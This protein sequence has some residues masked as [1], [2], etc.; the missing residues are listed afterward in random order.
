MKV[1]FWLT[2][3]I[4]LSFCKLIVSQDRITVEEYI[5]MYKDL[6]IEEMQKH[7]IPASIT[8]A[9]GLLESNTGNSPLAQQANNHF[10]IKC[11]KEWT[12]KTFYQD[13]DEK[14]ECFRKYAKAEDSYRDHSDYLRS[15]KRYA[16]LFELKVTDYKGWSRGLKKAGY[17]TSPTYAEKLID[18]IEDYNLQKYDDPSTRTN[19]SEK[20]VPQQSA[21]TGSRNIMENNRVKY[22]LAAEGD[23]YE[24]LTDEFGKLQWELP[25]YN[26]AETGY[27]VVP[28]QIVYIQPKRKKAESGKQIHVTRNGE[29][30]HDIAQKFAVKLSSLYGM[31]NIEPGVEPET[32]TVLQLRKAVKASLPEI[33]ND[34]SP[35]GNNGDDSIKVELNFD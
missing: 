30:M 35:S 20:P 31:N 4:F 1:Y 25:S 11:H 29:T 33:I 22:I 23:T 27:P 6:A 13:D 15:T 10:G 28:G 2:G 34:Q 16:S 14:D 9:Q 19:F 17:A 24:S 32:G 21:N 8:L 12:G 18:I 7:R 5:D 26:D 3:L